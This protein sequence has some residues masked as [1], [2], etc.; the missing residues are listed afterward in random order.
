MK[1]KALKLWSKLDSTTKLAI[2]VFCLYLLLYVVVDI[3]EAIARVIVMI[4]T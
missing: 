4:L 2:G 3:A 1:A